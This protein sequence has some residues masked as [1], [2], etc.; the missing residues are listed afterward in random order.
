MRQAT[1]PSMSWIRGQIIANHSFLCAPS[2]P[3]AKID[4]I[5]SLD[6]GGYWHAHVIH[7]T[8]TTRDDVLSGSGRTFCEAMHALLVR[9]SQNV[10]HFRKVYGASYRR[11]CD[12]DDESDADEDEDLDGDD[13]DVDLDDDVSIW[14]DGSP[15]PDESDIDEILPA[16]INKTSRPSIPQSSSGCIEQALPQR[17]APDVSSNDRARSGG[18]TAPTP[19]DWPREPV[20]SKHPSAPLV[21]EKISQGRRAVDEIGPQGTEAHQTQTTINTTTS[22]QT[23]TPPP[24]PPSQLAV[25]ARGPSEAQA[26]ISAYH[27]RLAVSVVTSGATSENPS[28]YQ[29]VTTITRPTLHA[30]LGAAVGH[31]R[32]ISAPDVAGETPTLRARVKRVEMGDSMWDLGGYRI[33]D[34]SVFFAPGPNGPA[35]PLFEIEVEHATGLSTAT[36]GEDGK[37]CSVEA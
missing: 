16:S 11:D 30:L 35:L 15:D 28:A 34:M 17:G 31:I 4:I 6:E 36:L 10:S 9:S 32:T 33:D 26:P 14:N 22:A 37:P 24:P 21:Q 3:D 20:A 1:L 19:A 25:E 12:L 5:T 23:T 27:V 2:P 8:N 7:S 29:M 18:R 13:A